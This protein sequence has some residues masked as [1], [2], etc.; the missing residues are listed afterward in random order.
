MGHTLNG[1]GYIEKRQKQ[2]VQVC[3]CPD[4]QERERL[5]EFVSVCKS[6]TYPYGQVQSVV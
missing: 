2:S 5:R 6:V 1:G 3:V 4:R